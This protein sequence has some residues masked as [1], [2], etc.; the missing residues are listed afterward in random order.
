MYVL[1]LVTKM[2]E[3]A[4]INYTWKFMNA[5]KKDIYL[6]TSLQICCYLIYFPRESEATC[7][8]AFLNDTCNQKRKNAENIICI[9]FNL[10]PKALL[11][12]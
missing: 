4:N 9:C 5:K 6:S 7:Y 2:Q 10:F 12:T 3:Q 8:L 1:M 11:M